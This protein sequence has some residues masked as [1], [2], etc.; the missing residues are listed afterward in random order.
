M[1]SNL[2]PRWR[3]MTWVLL[4]WSAVFG[5]WMVAGTAE[6]PSKDCAADSSVIDGT[7]TLSQCQ[8]ASDVGT[9][10]GVVLIGM[11]WFVGFLVLALVWL[12]SRPRKQQILVVREA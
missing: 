5:F 1:L 2:R 12:M 7:L 4:I 10:I 9:G 8:A 11:L 6:R 3:K